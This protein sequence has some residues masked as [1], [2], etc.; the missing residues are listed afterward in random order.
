MADV[1]YKINNKGTDYNIASTAY[2]TCTTAAAAVEKIANLQDSSS[3]TF[4]NNTI[5]TG[6]TVH[7]KF[8]YS[9][10]ASNPTLNVNNSGAKTII[11][12]GTTKAGTS[13]KTSWKAGA[14]VAFTF[15]GTYW[16]MNTSKD[17]NTDTDT[18]NTAGA[19]ANNNNILHLIGAMDQSAN[20]QT[21]TSGV[22]IGN[23][24]TLYTRSMFIN[25]GGEVWFGGSEGAIISENGRLQIGS[26]NGI[27]MTAPLTINGDLI[28]GNDTAATQEWAINYINEYMGGSTPDPEPDPEPDD[29]VPVTVGLYLEHRDNYEDSWE[30][31]GDYIILR[32]FTGDNSDGANT[33]EKHIKFY[34]QYSENNRYKLLVYTSSEVPSVSCSS[35]GDMS[36]E[37]VSSSNEGRYK[38]Y[39]V[40]FTEDEETMFRYWYYINIAATGTIVHIGLTANSSR[41]ED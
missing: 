15:D 36:L 4:C 40:K 5:P 18:K 24:S 19:T 26:Q 25:Q 8:T 32:Q 20:P 41:Y 39:L 33:I 35:S 21:Y 38:T 29:S 3:N 14:I 17:S 6:I 34:S 7:V 37:L 13:E 30:R 10:T 12:Y 23:D 16:V 9:N 27:H 1:I 2:C 31:E 28:M 11:T 22:Y